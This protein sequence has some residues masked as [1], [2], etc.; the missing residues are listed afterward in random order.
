MQT[1]LDIAPQRLWRVAQA[2]AP[3]QFAGVAAP[4]DL[5][6]W[7]Y[8]C[9]TVMPQCIDS[10]QL[11]PFQMGV[12]HNFEYG[13]YML[14]SPSALQAYYSNTYLGR[15]SACLNSPGAC[16]PE[17]AADLQARCFESFSWRARQLL[18]L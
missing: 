10:A 2:R 4:G 5:P 8:A 7:R 15:L 1:Q 13:E 14:V 17:V 6:G 9:D 3:G 16:S 11:N 18:F 12:Q